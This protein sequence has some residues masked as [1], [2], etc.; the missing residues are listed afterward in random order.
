MEFLDFP[1][2]ETLLKAIEDR[3]FTE[4]T[5]IQEKAIPLLCEKDID[6]VGQAQTGTGKTA[7]FT[8]PLLQRINPSDRGVQAI[9]L[10]PTRELANQICEEMR[11]FCTH[12]KI[13]VFS[14]YGG[15]PI[16]K[17]IGQLKKLK[18]Q[19]IVGTPGRVKDLIYRKS[20]K[21]EGAKYA[22]LDEADEMLDMGFLDD[23]KEILANVE[24]KKTWMFS[25]TM[26]KAILDLINNYLND[27]EVVRVKKKTLSN[28]NI[29]Q[30]FY[31]V[32]DGDM[33]EAVGRLLD[34][35]E[36]YYGI[37]FTKTKLEA[38]SLTDE[39]GFRGFLVDSL[40]GDMDQKH[41]DLT[42]RKFKD[43][44]VKLLVCTDVAARGIDVDH[45]THVINFGLP[46]DL[47]SYVHR[48]G[49]TGRAG[50][51][52]IALSVINPSEM[53]RIYHLENLTKAKILRDRIPTPELIKDS[54][55]RRTLNQ[56]EFLFDEVKN[57]ANTDGAFELFCD[58]FEDLNKEDVLDVMFK[59]IFNESI[60]R[61]DRNPIIDLEPKKRGERTKVPASKIVP[62]SRGNVRLFVNVGKSDGVNLND[63]VFNVS[64][65]LNIE[66]RKIR[67]V[68]LKDKFS[69]LDVPANFYEKLVF[70]AKLSV[71]NK[72]IRFE[73][74]SDHVAGASSR[75][76]R[77]RGNYRGGSSRSGGNRR[78]GGSRGNSRGNSRGY[79]R[80]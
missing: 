56:F 11:K 39:L 2:K 22:V 14:V 28:E 3:G 7:A 17:Q 50:H 37:I 25:A 29:T 67:N 34:S 24:E 9:V 59:Y 64:D 31:V 58:E 33:R 27:P 6:F 15:V 4:P 35:F 69:F 55:V 74:T 48:I 61:L 65:E 71:G 5:E 42:M 60:K 21:I 47:E 72:I 43:K 68:Q 45:L 16:D 23:V 49:R 63:L 26:P 53:R 1:L 36:D 32:K 38:K 73:A 75:D 79:N 80:R 41:R 70:D 51:K 12:E 18:P 8:L 77:G 10:S 76:G 66:K 44:K 13:R 54:M 19:I 57:N 46:Q 62:D 40:H 52:G 20:L 30:K 78:T